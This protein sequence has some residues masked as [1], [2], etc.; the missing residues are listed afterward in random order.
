MRTKMAFCLGLVLASATVSLTLPARADKIVSESS[1]SSSTTEAV[2]DKKG[3]AFKYGERLKNWSETIEKG[4]AKGWLTSDEAATFK[5]RWD[6]L[7]TLNDSVSA[8]GYPKAELDDM[9]KQF[10]KFNADLSTASS[11]PKTAGGAA[12]TTTTTTKTKPAVTK[13][14]TNKTTTKTTTK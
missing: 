7:K 10:T 6:Q 5:S 3:Y 13:S 1:S 4:V 2:V 14:A 8:K 9:E 11:K 12:S